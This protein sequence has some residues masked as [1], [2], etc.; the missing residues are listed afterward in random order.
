MRGIRDVA[1][2]ERV[3][4][5]LHAGVSVS[6]AA[7]DAGVSRQTVYSWARR[8]DREVAVALGIRAAGGS[9]APEKGPATDE[10]TNEDLSRRAK[11]ALMGLLADETPQIRAKAVE[12]VAKHYQHADVPGD[13]GAEGEPE[14]DISADD[15]AARFR[16]VD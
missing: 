2:R 7:S 14:S 12:I 8:G 15:A 5:A 1:A 16:V 13:E 3:I 6:K 4:R 9:V 11:V 10:I